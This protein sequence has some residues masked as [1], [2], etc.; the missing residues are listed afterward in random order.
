MFAE[1]QQEKLFL[2]C[3][4]FMP[5][6]RLERAGA[7]CR[8]WEGRKTFVLLPTS[9]KRT[10]VWQMKSYKLQEV[11]TLRHN[12]VATHNKII[13]L[14]LAFVFRCP[15]FTVPIRY[16][17]ESLAKKERSETERK[18]ILLIWFNLRLRFEC[19]Q[20]RRKFFSFLT[21]LHSVTRRANNSG[22]DEKIEKLR[23][24][25]IFTRHKGKGKKSRAR[26]EG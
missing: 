6:K 7:F 4:A 15:F 26:K 17:K 22:V 21:C 12:T 14:L 16:A 20:P 9:A 11:A 23:F 25:R 5:L 24:V 2:C 19:K 18:Q 10:Q 13:K 1:Q 3:F 8:R